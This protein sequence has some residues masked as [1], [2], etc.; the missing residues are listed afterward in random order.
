MSIH[1]HRLGTGNG[2]RNRAD[3]NDVN[4]ILD[5]L[6]IDSDV[7][8]IDKILVKV[9]LLLQITGGD[10]A[11]ANRLCITANIFMGI[12]VANST[13]RTKVVA[14]YLQPNRK[15]CTKT[16]YTH[17][18][19]GDIRTF[20]TKSYIGAHSVAYTIFYDHL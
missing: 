1:L 15:K 18:S 7:I 3:R 11:H 5:S 6:H 16:A 14:I 20:S 2:I 8:S 13:V 10:Q 19:G 9:C 4:M 17:Q 12:S